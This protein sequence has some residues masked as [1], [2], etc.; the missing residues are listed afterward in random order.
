LSPFLPDRDVE[1]EFL[2]ALV[3]LRLAQVPGRPGA[4]DHDARE[5]PFPAI[6]QGHHADID[7]AL[8]ED[9]VAHD[10]V[11]DVVEGL[12]EG[13]APLLDVVDN[14]VGMSWRTPPKRK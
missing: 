2:V 4:A 5:A 12:G 10:E 8:L 13:V 14:S 1:V 9:A 7:V 6:L 11:V 3:G